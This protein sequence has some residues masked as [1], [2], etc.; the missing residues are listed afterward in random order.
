MADKTIDREQVTSAL[1]EAV[2]TMDG[3]SR[4]GFHQIAAIAKL[5]ITSMGTVEGLKRAD[6]IL[7]ALRAILDKAE[8]MAERISDQANHV[9]CGRESP[10]EMNYWEATAAIQDERQMEAM[11]AIQA[12]RRGG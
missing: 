4:D 12:E 6:N 9:G 1:R 5:S 11:A 10:L 8:D 2:E 7:H 3:L